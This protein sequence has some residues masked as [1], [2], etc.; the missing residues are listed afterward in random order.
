[1]NFAEIETTW[2]SPHNR[3]TPAQLEKQKMNVI[4]ELNRRRRSTRGLLWLTAIPLV[5]ITGKLALH[6]LWPDPAL[7]RIQVAREWAVIPFFLL[8]WAGWLLMWWL[9]RGHTVQHADFARSIRAGVAALLDENRRE[10]L[11]TGVIAALLLGSVPL[12]GGVVWQLRAVGKAGDE[13][14]LPAFVIYPTYV[15]LTLGWIAFDYF[16]KTQPRGRELE[17]LLA[18]YRED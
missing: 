4:D 11:R 8:P 16:R 6:L 2:R 18:Q 15:L 17:G 10:R 13:I 3:P 7:D 5:L 14:L 9:H 1:M 12:L